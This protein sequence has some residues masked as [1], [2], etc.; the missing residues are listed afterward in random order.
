MRINPRMPVQ[1]L[2]ILLSQVAAEFTLRHL[3]EHS[4][5]FAP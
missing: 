5:G 3:F 1:F 4:H 2:N